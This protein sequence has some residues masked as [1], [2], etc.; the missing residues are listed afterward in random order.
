M[1]IS[2]ALRAALAVTVTISLSACS[3]MKSGAEKAVRDM[4]SDPESARFGEFY[5]N[6]KTKFACLTFNAKNQMGG[7]VGDRQ[8]M[9]AYEEGKWHY[10]GASETDPET[11]RKTFADKVD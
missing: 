9:L 3:G 2:I 1:Q 7:Y 11:C 5:Y 10:G 4:L 8:A 6:S